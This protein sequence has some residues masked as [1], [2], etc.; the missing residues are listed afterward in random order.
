M[1]TGVMPVD[2]S[3]LISLQ[4]KKRQGR[5]LKIVKSC[6][7]PVRGFALDEVFDRLQQTFEAELH[8]R[9]AAGIYERPKEQVLAQVQHF[10]RNGA[11]GTL[12]YAGSH[13]MTIAHID[14]AKALKRI[15]AAFGAGK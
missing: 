15:K 7:L 14:L 3:V 13:S 6:S 4:H 11:A 1:K 2:Q 8:N 10:T 9:A 12:K 5:A